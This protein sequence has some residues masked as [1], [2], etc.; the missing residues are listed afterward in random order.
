MILHED[1]FQVHFLFTTL[2]YCYDVLVFQT[3]NK[4]GNEYANH[5]ASSSAFTFR[6][7]ARLFSASALF[8]ASSSNLQEIKSIIIQA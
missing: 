7:A 2:L 1:S 8:W 3:Q 5:P 6:K 4:T